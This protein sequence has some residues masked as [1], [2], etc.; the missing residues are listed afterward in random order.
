MPVATF[1][2]DQLM[3]ILAWL[4]DQKEAGLNLDEVIEGLENGHLS[5]RVTITDR[6]HSSY[7]SKSVESE[8]VPRVPEEV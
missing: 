2:P 3:A 1:E 7:A 6:R 5:T 8:D 4:E